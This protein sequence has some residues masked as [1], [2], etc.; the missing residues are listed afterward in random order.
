MSSSRKMLRKHLTKISDRTNAVLSQV[1]HLSG[2]VMQA[3][4]YLT[5]VVTNQKALAALAT[6]YIKILIFH[7]A[8]YF[9]IL[10]FLLLDSLQYL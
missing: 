6:L 10:N 2:G 5:I 7:G 3:H 9:F 1:K 8:L 4:V